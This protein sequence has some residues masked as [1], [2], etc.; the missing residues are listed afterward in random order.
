LASSLEFGRGEDGTVLVAANER[1]VEVG[2]KD[3]TGSYIERK[4]TEHGSFIVL[5]KEVFGAYN[6]VHLLLC[7]HLFGQIHTLGHVR[8]QNFL[9]VDDVAEEYFLDRR[10]QVYHFKVN[11]KKNEVSTIA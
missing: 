3:V 11:E 6:A 2:Q 8:S 1:L 7:V 10:I 4:G 9:T 5:P